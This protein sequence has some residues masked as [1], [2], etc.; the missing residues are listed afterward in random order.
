MR[1][2]LDGYERA[3]SRAGAADEFQLTISAGP[4]SGTDALHAFEQAVSEI[5][6][7]LE[8]AVS[9]YEGRDHAILD[10]RLKR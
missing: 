4:F 3:V 6:G 9:G 7:V 2:L 5:Q 10:V 8:V 1:E